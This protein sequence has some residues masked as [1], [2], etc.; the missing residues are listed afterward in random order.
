MGGAFASLSVILCVVL[1]GSLVPQ[2]LPDEAYLERYGESLGRMFLTL[3]LDDVF[4]TRGFMAVGA[5]LFL[6]L[7]ACTVR[8]SRRLATDRRLP[9]AGSVL[10]H[11]GLLVFLASVGVSL[12]WGRTVHI[13]AP[14]GKPVSLASQG[15]PFELRLEKFSIDY[16]PDHRSVRQYRSAVSLLRDGGVWKTGSLE[17]NEPLSVDGIKIYQM[18]YGWL[19]EGTI[20]QLPDGLPESFS[21]PNGDWV[22]YSGSAAEPLRVAAMADPD[23]TGQANPGAAFLVVPTG[24]PRR[25]G[26]VMTGASVVSGNVE[27]RFERLRRFSGLQLKQDPGVFGIFGGLAL[28]LCGLVLRYLPA[29][30]ERTA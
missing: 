2:G 7:C 17:V 22:P 8:R 10:L 1:F 12:W 23:R 4:R 26:V 3:G 16:Y 19:V 20:R 9:L 29:G 18:S 11:V 14:E 21:V 5:V 28:A 27:L 24:G 13:E 30:K 25:S 6:Q 15:F